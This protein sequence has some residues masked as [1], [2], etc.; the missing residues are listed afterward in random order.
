MRHS[1]LEHLGVIRPLCVRSSLNIGISSGNSIILLSTSYAME[2]TL[3]AL[4]GFLAIFVMLVTVISVCL[5]CLLCRRRSPSSDL[6][7]GL[8][9][10]PEAPTASLYEE[11]KL[12]T[13]PVAVQDE[14]SA[15]IFEKCDLP[16]ATTVLESSVFAPSAPQLAPLEDVQR[17]QYCS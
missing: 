6:L 13:A 9:A 11:D 17:Q 14:P 8:A 10:D 16:S 5:Y 15:P 3:L 1:V 7:G 2:L 4:A 12:P